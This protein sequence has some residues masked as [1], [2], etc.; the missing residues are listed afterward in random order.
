[1]ED[2]SESY[3][4]LIHFVFYYSQE[5]NSTEVLDQ[6]LAKIHEIQKDKFQPIAQELQGE[7]PH[8]FLKA[9]SPGM[10]V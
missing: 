9:Y 1:M 10:F 4:I 7:D 3:N 2:S 8:Q 6:A 5:K